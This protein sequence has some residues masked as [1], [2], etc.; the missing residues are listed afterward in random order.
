MARNWMLKLIVAFILVA[1]GGCNE[2][3]PETPTI[4]VGKVI[5]ENGLPV[6]GAGIVFYGIHEMGLSGYETFS[7][8]VETDKNGTYSISEVLSDKTTSL[9]TAPTSTDSISIQLGGYKPY[10]FIEGK[11][12][13]FASTYIL[14]RDNWGKTL[15]LNYQFLK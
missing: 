1:F 15:T 5:D 9:E 7:N 2:K 13:P 12:V 10:I 4:I 11:Y 8:K 6:K 14:P 3:T